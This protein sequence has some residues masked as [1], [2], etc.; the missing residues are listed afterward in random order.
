MVGIGGSQGKLEG[1]SWGTYGQDIL[2]TC[3]EFQKLNKV[4]FTKE[5]IHVIFL[6][7]INYIRLSHQ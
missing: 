6:A 2:N 5:N 3:M 1:R 4:L 7:S